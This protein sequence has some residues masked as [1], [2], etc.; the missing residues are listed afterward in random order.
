MRDKNYDEAVNQFNQ[1]MEALEFV[2]S[3][4][5]VRDAESQLKALL[6]EARAGQAQAQ[7]T[8][9]EQREYKALEEA[10]NATRQEQ[11][12]QERRKLALLS[13]A[14]AEYARGKYQSAINLG[15]QV[16]EIDPENAEV[17]DLV[18]DARAGLRRLTWDSI[19]DQDKK[20][21]EDERVR[22]RLKAIFPPALVQFPAKE[23]WEEIKARPSVELPSG[24]GVKTPVELALQDVLDQEIK[25][26]I[27][28]PENSPLSDWMTTIKTNFPEFYYQIDPDEVISPRLADVPV[29]DLSAVL[30]HRAVT[31]REVLEIVMNSVK[32]SDPRNATGTGMGGGGGGGGRGG[33]GGGRGGRGGGG[34]GG[35]GGGGG[36]FG[37]GAGVGAAGGV[38]VAGRLLCPMFI[39]TSHYIFIS[40]PGG[41]REEEARRENLED[42]KAFRQYDIADLMYTVETLATQAGNSGA[43]AGGAGGVGGAGGAGGGG[44]VGS[45][46]TSSAGTGGTGSSSNSGNSQNNQADLIPIIL[47]FTGQAEW[48]VVV[49]EGQNTTTTGSSRLVAAPAA[50]GARAGREAWEARAAWA[51][52]WAA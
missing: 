46:G 10:E 6:T 42:F 27:S 44:A 2:R 28:M 23:V 30:F 41:C 25:G 50:P 16:L 12:R 29:P 24:K 37:I 45:T 26:G 22:L 21:I 31:I 9:Q 14:N 1:A 17:A 15:Q 35:A 5:D 52:A 38:G 13:E 11:Q 20:S 4:Y 18:D 32:V 39:V 34:G 40:S 51:A 33:G 36:G 3:S 48:D 43:G 7:K 49:A 8:L 19:L 47:L